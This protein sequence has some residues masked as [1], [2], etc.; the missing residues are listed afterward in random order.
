MSPISEDDLDRLADYTAGVLDPPEAAE[1]DRLIATEPAWARAYDELTAAQPT[2]DEALSELPREPMPAD[3]AARLDLAVATA[4]RPGTAKVVPFPRRRWPRFA[5]TTAAAVAVGVAC[6]GGIAALNRYGGTS[7]T[8]SSGL[9][10]G[11]SA[12]APSPFSRAPV[13]PNTG[14]GA[15]AAGG[16]VP[17]TASGVDYTHGTLTMAASTTSK[18]PAAAHAESV[19]DGP[20]G[21]GRLSAPS[22]LDACLVA[23]TGAEG[24]RALSVDYARYQ[25]QPAL[26]VVLSGGSA[27]V[28][29]A[30]AGCGLPGEGAALLDSVG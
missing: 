24:G 12:T 19:P 23:I 17:T 14:A 27:S 16:T 20:G 22:A 5:L 6:V 9:A 10:K 25:G 2:L 13:L 3:V 18:A 15:G 4:S 29:A 21:L 8:S 7:S 30:G 1:V 11:D 28:V 26:I